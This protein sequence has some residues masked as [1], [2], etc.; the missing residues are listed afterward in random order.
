MAEAHQLRFAGLHALDKLRNF[1][2]RPNLM[3][4]VQRFF[5]GA[6]VQRTVE[7]GNRRGGGGV[8]ID[9]R[10]AHTADGVGGAVLLVIRV[11]NEQHVQ[12]MLQRRIRLIALSRGAEQHIQQISRIAEF[13]VGIDEWHAQRMAIGKGRNRGHLADHPVGLQPA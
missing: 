13:T 2:H 11:Q 4:H 10:A 8:R 12:R 5:V 9:V 6:A 7:R 3:Q 1:L